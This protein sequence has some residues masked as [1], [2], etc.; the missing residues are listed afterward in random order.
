MAKRSI[1]RQAFSRAVRK[2]A[3]EIYGPIAPPNSSPSE[4]EAIFAALRTGEPI[5]A[6]ETLPADTG[7]VDLWLHELDRLWRHP[8]S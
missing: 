5:D 4:L 3:D 8:P 2:Q 7:V 6:A 1:L